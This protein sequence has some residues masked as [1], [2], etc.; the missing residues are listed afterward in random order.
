MFIQIFKPS[1]FFPILIE[2]NPLLIIPSYFCQF[3]FNSMI[4]FTSRF[5]KCF[6]SFS[7]SQHD[8]VYTSI[9][10][11]TFRRQSEL[12]RRWYYRSILCGYCVV[13]WEHIVWLL[14]GVIRAYCVAISKF[15]LCEWSLTDLCFLDLPLIWFQ[16]ITKS[17]V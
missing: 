13:L 10:L 8:P 9:I 16:N 11:H 6:L 5:Y 15:C 12:I 3:H 4:S 17:S 14:C 7:F 1:L 2:D